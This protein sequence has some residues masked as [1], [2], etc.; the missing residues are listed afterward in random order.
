MFELILFAAPDGMAQGIRC[1]CARGGDE[2]LLL[3][4]WLLLILH[5]ALL[6]TALLR[7]LDLLLWSNR[8]QLALGM[9]LAGG[10]QRCG[11]FA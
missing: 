9:S 1:A 8:L 3:R 10:S 4:R 7:R 11:E 6:A 5:A 2:L